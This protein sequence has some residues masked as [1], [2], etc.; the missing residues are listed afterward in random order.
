M[1][2]GCIMVNDIKKLYRERLNGIGK[3]KNLRVLLELFFATNS[4]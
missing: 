1:I 2:Y 3:S 4:L